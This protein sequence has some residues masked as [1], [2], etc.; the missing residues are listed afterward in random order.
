MPRP[1]FSKGHYELFAKVLL[2]HLE[3]QGPSAQLDDITVRLADLFHTDNPHFNEW[4]FLK[5]CKAK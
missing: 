5:A 4:R 1:K 3:E 2:E